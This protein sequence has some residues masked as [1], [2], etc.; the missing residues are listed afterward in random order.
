MN[1]DFLID[2]HKGNKR[3]GPGSDEHTKQALHLAGLLGGG[4]G[5]QVADLGCGTGAPTLILAACLKAR[6][7]AVDLFQDFLDV[8]DDS[9]KAQGLSDQI[10]TH[11]GSMEALPFAEGHFDVIWAEGS[12]YNMGFERGVRD[13]RPFL[14]SGGILAVSE[15]TWL[16]HER[17]QEIQQ[18]W[19]SEYPEIATASEKIC[20]LERQGFLLKGYFPLPQHCWTENY[21]RPL[22]TACDRF[23][24][25]HESGAA[26]AIVEAEKSEIA[27]Y[28]KY[29]RYYSYGFYIAQKL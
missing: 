17:P 14:K 6:I 28:E 23:L 1:V 29:S 13:L 20:C 18:H 24:A 11:L 22:A 7:I 5:L 26:R 15:L 25:R 3:Q 27:L 10:T 19:D 12:I 16:T 2:L 21:Y 4:R 8:L 9:A